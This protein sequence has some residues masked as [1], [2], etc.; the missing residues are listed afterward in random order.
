MAGWAVL[1]F[2]RLWMLMKAMSDTSA[3]SPLSAYASFDPPTLYLVG[4]RS[5]ESVH[6][7]ARLGWP[8]LV[9]T[10]R[11]ELKNP[12]WV[13]PRRQHRH[14]ETGDLRSVD[15][16]RRAPVNRA[17]LTGRFPSLSRA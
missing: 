8:G 6:G 13:Q 7:A 17:G 1:K 11:S 14:A 15:N 5:P 3:A 2:L 9:P 16:S 4:G 12:T 10:I